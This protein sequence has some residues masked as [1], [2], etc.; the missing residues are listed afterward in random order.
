[1]KMKKL[2]RLAGMLTL[3]WSFTLIAALLITAIITSAIISIVYIVGTVLQ[4]CLPYKTI[5]V[6]VALAVLAVLATLAVLYV[7][8]NLRRKHCSR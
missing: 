3:G 7:I 6:L 1:M 8:K 5:T 4:V 2:A